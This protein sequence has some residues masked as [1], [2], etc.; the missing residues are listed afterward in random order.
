M[1]LRA[2]STTALQWTLAAL[3]RF[4]RFPSLQRRI[5]EELAVRA[6]AERIERDLPRMIRWMRGG[7]S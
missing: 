6:W 4:D 7:L 5:D 2:L 1:K 3:K